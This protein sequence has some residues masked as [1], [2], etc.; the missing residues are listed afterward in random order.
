MTHHM[1][2]H[3]NP[4]TLSGS[5]RIPPSKSHTLRAILFASLAEG[6]SHIHGYLPSPDT[7]AMIKACQQLGAYI[8]P[9][10]TTLNIKGTAGKPNLPNDVIDA[11]NSGQV[12]RFIA[13]IAGLINGHVV[14]TGDASI[15][16]NRPISPLMKGLS[17]LGATCIS[18]KGDDHAPVIIKGPTTPG[19][20]HLDGADSQPVSALLIA[21]AFMEGTTTIKVNNAGEKPWIDLTLAWLDRLAI[22]YEHDNYTHYKI[23]GGNTIQAF[24]YTVPGDFSAMAYPL[25]AALITQSNITIGNI[26]M[27]DAQGDKKIIQTLQNMGAHIITHENQLDITP[28]NPLQGATIDVNDFIDALPILAVI[29]CYT[30]KTTTLYNAAIARKKES[31]RLATITQELRK[32]GANITEKSDTL[33]ITP[34]PLHGAKLAAHNDHRIA[35]SLAVAAL[36]AQGPST[37]DGCQCIA[38]SYPN[39]CEDMNAL[40]ANIKV[41]P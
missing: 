6:E 29:A 8:E 35:M 41:T 26:D 25:A 18:T 23:H 7:Q 4:S 16:F 24:E 3:L 36:G 28:S 12:L 30:Q 33:I 9:S 5:V 27:T 20:A 32:M 15:R 10:P 38:K 13:A 2:Y 37:I 11:G 40:G 17:D 34:A 21:S 14:I 22:D 19:T 31:D 1:Q 39:F